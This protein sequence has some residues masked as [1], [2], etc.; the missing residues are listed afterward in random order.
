MIALGCLLVGHPGYKTLIEALDT[1]TRL[2]T[3]L[4]RLQEKGLA[5][6]V[7]SLGNEV[8]ALLE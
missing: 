8:I 3:A 2:K 7:I 5:S 4:H 1:S 6:Q